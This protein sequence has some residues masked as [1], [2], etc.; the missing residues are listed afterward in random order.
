MGLRI[1]K[2]RQK[3]GL[4]PTIRE[5]SRFFGLDEKRLMLAKEDAIILH[6]GPVNRGVE[7][8]TSVIDGEQSLI[9]EQV[10]NGVAIRMALLYLLTRR[11][12][13][14]ETVN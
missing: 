13:M 5:Y 3:K 11:S 1:Q 2:E 8:T 12:G 4:F 6:P 10:T 9:N 7:L 14:S